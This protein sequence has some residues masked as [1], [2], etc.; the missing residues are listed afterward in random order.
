[1]NPTRSK[2]NSR[3]VVSYLLLW[4]CFIRSFWSSWCSTYRRF[5]VSSS[6]QRTKTP[7]WTTRRLSE[8]LN[9][10]LNAVTQTS[11]R[12]LSEGL[13]LCSSSA[14]DICAGQ[15]LGSHT[16][17]YRL[18]RLNLTVMMFTLPFTQWRKKEKNNPSDIIESHF[19]N[20]FVIMLTLV[21]FVTLDSIGGIYQPMIRAQPALAIFFM[22]KN[23]YLSAYDQGT[24]GSSDIFY[25]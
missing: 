16:P 24:T 3:Y 8:G 23:E 11:I 12:R 15:S 2:P 22:G 10:C 9:L 6:S 5:Y 7:T 19:P 17:Y 20:L 18:P 21:Q 25:G 13:N 14:I 1:M 4:R